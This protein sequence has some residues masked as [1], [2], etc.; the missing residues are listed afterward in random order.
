[1]NSSSAKAEEKIYYNYKWELKYWQT[2]TDPPASS[3]NWKKDHATSNSLLSPS[4]TPETKPQAAT[5]A[6]SSE[7]KPWRSTAAT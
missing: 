3:M 4:T 5:R 1:M 2:T 7:S 6:T